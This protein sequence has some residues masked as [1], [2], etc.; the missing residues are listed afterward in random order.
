ML[1]NSASKLI[2][3]NVLRRSIIIISV[4]HSTIENCNWFN[5]LIIDDE[6]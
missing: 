4:I 6:Y 1:L 2:L 3:R 5:K